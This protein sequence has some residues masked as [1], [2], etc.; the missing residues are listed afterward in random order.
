[1][2]VVIWKT[3]L[4]LMIYYCWN[5][6][7]YDLGNLES[8]G[9]LNL[10]NLC[11]YCNLWLRGRTLREPGLKSKK[12][13]M[14]WQKYIWTQLDKHKLRKEKKQLAAFVYER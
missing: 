1:M 6:L 7:I 10:T 5:F 4:M 2:I 3:Q 13:S 9:H 14:S 11:K 8:I 12:V